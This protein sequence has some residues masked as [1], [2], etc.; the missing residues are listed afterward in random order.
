MGSTVR[1]NT[2]VM[3][4]SVI[5]PGLM[6]CLLAGR[7]VTCCA[8]EP[9][10]RVAPV[11]IRLIRECEV[12]AHDSGVLDQISVLE[13]MPVKE[14]DLLAMLES[15]QQELTV[16]LAKLNLEASE[17]EASNDL[18]V[19]AAEEGLL[20]AQSKLKTLE[21]SLRVAKNVSENTS[22][23]EIAKTDQ[24]TSRT[25]LDRAKTARSQ[26]DKSVSE[27]EMIRLTADFR[28]SELSVSEA[29]SKQLTSELQVHVHTAELEE[30][31]AAI[32]RNRHLVEQERRKLKQAART[33][34]TRRV[35]LDLA[36]A[37][38]DRRKVL[39]PLAGIVVR[40]SRQ[41][42]EFVEAGTPIL[43]VIQ[44]DRLR[45]EGFVEVAIAS[46]ALKNRPVRI[47]VTGIGARKKTL[48]GVITFVGQEV[49]PL[50][51]QVRVWAEFESPE[52]DVYPGMTA[53]MTILSGGS[54]IPAAQPVTGLPEDTEPSDAGAKP[55][56]R[57]A[58]VDSSGER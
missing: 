29:E 55:V 57:S 21:L 11:T 16:E 5:V 13:G 44:L 58:A 46:P 25:Q 8:N 56:D 42:G 27:A 32:S 34:E 10:I 12:P 48:S 33:S 23:V 3:I 6:T 53:E 30:Q 14:G 1:K 18:A 19:L 40:H 43:R 51:Q 9:E 49:D 52:L 15:R 22:A 24:A 37:M 47:E 39:S 20:E 38:L 28:K 31:Q 26:F 7:G 54:P 35:E 36:K 2:T 41:P 4:R 17:E 45:A 50:N